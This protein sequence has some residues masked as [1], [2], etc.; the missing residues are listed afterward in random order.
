M[1]DKILI[2]NDL[3]FK[4][5]I[6]KSPGLQLALTNNANGTIAIGRVSPF[7]NTAVTTP[8]SPTVTPE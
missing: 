5:Q 4:I 6:I 1:N 3:D 2:V 7:E 8:S